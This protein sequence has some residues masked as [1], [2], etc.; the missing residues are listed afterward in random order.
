MNATARVTTTIRGRGAD[1][2]RFGVF[3]SG[4]PRLSSRISHCWSHV[5][6][7]PNLSRISVLHGF[8]FPVVGSYFV[9]VR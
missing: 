4:C 6:R 3:I 9:T 2:R 5:D 1:L 8:D 7:A